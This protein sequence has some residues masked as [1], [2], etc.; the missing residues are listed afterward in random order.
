MPQPYDTSLRT[1][2]QDNVNETIHASDVNAIATNLNGLSGDANSG[3]PLDLPGHKVSTST[4]HDSRYPLKTG[5]TLAHPTMSDYEDFT[6]QSSDP[7]SPA[8]GT[9]RVY[10]KSG[11]IFVKNSAGTVIGALGAGGGG[12]A[13]APFQF[14][15]Y[16][17]APVSGD[18]SKIRESVATTHTT[19]GA[20]R[21][22]GTGATIDVLKNGVS[23]LTA[24]LSLTGTT[25]TTA[26]LIASPNG[27]AG[28]IITIVL[29]GVTGSPSEIL[30]SLDGSRATF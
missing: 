22:G 5:G 24:P 10:S 23:I 2:H 19:F 3:G 15:P 21:S 7:S 11:G 14:A 30:T 28:D 18:Q 4:D 1:T 12:G 9:H 25:W 20:Q 26:T 17:P 13:S 29:S 27:A 8:A 16:F 6:D